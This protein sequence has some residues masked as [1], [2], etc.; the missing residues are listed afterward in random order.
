MNHQKKL[1]LV[2][3]V[4]K[5]FPDTVNDDVLLIQKVWEKEG[6]YIS[7]EQLKKVTHAETITR[8]RR[9]AFNMGLIEYSSKAM[10][11]RETAFKNEREKA[12]PMSPQIENRF[13]K[14]DQTIRNH[15]DLDSALGAAYSGN[16]LPVSTPYKQQGLL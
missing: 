2:V 9:Q 4:M 7:Y 1:Q 16:R 12:S 5:E 14:Y 10:R 11:S 8:R 15:A 3:S 6:L 13:P